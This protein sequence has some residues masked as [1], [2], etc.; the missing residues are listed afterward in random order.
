M[1]S[2]VKR[3]VAANHGIPRGVISRKAAGFG[4]L[5]FYSLRRTCITLMAELGVPLPVTRDAVG[6]MSDS[7]TRHYTHIQ[8]RVAQAAVEKLD[9]LRNA[10]PFLDVLVDEAQKI[11]LRK[12][13]GSA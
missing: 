5:R 7:V 10:P 8:D 1:C 6:H 11:E 3:P 4:K 13:P 12:R 2:S 9:Q